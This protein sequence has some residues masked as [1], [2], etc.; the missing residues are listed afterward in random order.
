MLVLDHQHELVAVDAARGVDFIGRQL[1]AVADRYA[2]LGRAA[3][4]G[5]RHAQLDVGRMGSRDDTGSD[6]RG[7]QLLGLGLHGC[8]HLKVCLG[9]L[10]SGLM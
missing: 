1:E 7:Q 6:Q 5:F 2:V 9:I 4:Q 8:Y 3:G 10:V